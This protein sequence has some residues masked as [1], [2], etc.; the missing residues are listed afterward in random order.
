V[1]TAGPYT[2]SI[3]KN[4]EEIA[5]TTAGY[6][7]VGLQSD[8]L[9]F[10]T[11][12]PSA[13]CHTHTRADSLQAMSKPELGSMFRIGV[14]FLALDEAFEA[15]RS[16]RAFLFYTGLKRYLARFVPPRYFERFSRSAAMIDILADVKRT[17]AESGPGQAYILHIM[18]PHFP[19]LLDAD[20]NVKPV[21]MWRSPPRY[22]RLGNRQ[23]VYQ[24]YWDQSVCAN[25]Q[26]FELVDRVLSA[27]FGQ[28][29]I[30]MVHGDHGSRFGRKTD[31]ADMLENRQ[32]LLAVKTPATTGRLFEDEVSLQLQFAEQFR[33]AIAQEAKSAAYR[34]GTGFSPR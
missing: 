5:L 30:I 13:S 22:D 27:P 18:L 31:D 11:D 26:V 23:S 17:V 3:V 10:C 7:I 19:Y 21:A 20:C 6:R 8:Y 29:A 1:R 25:R 14:A 2:W 28:R 12:S 15:P 34:V 33:A 9:N 24:A 16:V 32:T 4:A